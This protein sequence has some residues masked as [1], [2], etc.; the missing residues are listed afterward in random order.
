MHLPFGL[1]W[2]E[3]IVVGAFLI[4]LAMFIYFFLFDKHDE[5]PADDQESTGVRPLTPQE[6]EAAVQP[7][8]PG[9][10]AEAPESTAQ[11]ADLSRDLDLDTTGVPLAEPTTPRTPVEPETH[12]GSSDYIGGVRFSG[13]LDYHPA[14]PL[15]RYR[16]NARIYDR[17]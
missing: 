12:D 14:P 4:V 17:E 16:R 8:I 9:D 5:A 10:R 15:V 6:W 2:A 7:H 11:R 13:T 3:I 1:S